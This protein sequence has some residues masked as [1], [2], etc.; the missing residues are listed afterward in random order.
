MGRVE[1]GLGGVVARGAGGVVRGGLG[2]GGGCWW[3]VGRRRGGGRV[4]WRWVFSL[5]LLRL[6]TVEKLWTPYEIYLKL[7]S[8]SSFSDFS[9]ACNPIPNHPMTKHPPPTV[10]QRRVCAWFGGR[11][12]YVHMFEMWSNPPVPIP[13]S[14]SFA[15]FSAAIT[16]NAIDR[17]FSERGRAESICR[18]LEF[19]YSKEL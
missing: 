4:K 2:Q 16:I 7:Y 18:S 14:N 19:G 17:S 3:L 13:T 5:V 12:I 15:L 6:S 9:H 8:R 10:A 1:L 11:S